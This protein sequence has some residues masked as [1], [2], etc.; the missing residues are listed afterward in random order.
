MRI[1]RICSLLPGLTIWPMLRNKGVPP[2]F[3]RHPHK[4]ILAE[5]RWRYHGGKDESLNSPGGGYRALIHRQGPRTRFGA[6]YYSGLS[7]LAQQEQT[8]VAA[9]ST[10]SVRTVKVTSLL[11]GG[12]DAA[13]TY[14]SDSSLLAPE[15]DSR[16]AYP[17]RKWMRSPHVLDPAIPQHS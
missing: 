15:Q 14:R 4:Q 5:L 7:G 17:A 9:G 3:P 2:Y 16:L 1:L 11:M 8:L 10:G 6:R 13:V 12:D